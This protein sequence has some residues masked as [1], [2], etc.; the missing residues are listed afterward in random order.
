MAVPAA[1]TKATIGIADISHVL[2]TFKT[3]FPVGDKDRNFNLKLA[4]SKLNG[5]V[6]QPGVEFS[7]NGVVG[8]R[9]EKEGYKIA[10]VI[11]AGEMVDG[12]AGGTCQISTTL[13]GASFFAGLE[14]VKTSPHSR[15][16][17]YVTIGL[18]ATVVYPTTDLIM[19]MP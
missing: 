6:L 10:H 5:H 4:A 9:T 14:V 8:D 7:F 11:T 19:K 2:G 17:T 12:L 1:N 3:T 16:S 13:F 18:D 15:P